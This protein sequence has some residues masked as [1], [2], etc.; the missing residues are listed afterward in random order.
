MMDGR[1]QSDGCIV[2]TKSPN[3]PEGTEGMEGRQP[4]KGNEQQGHISRTQGRREDMSKALERIRQAVRRDKKDKL[5]ALYH[6]VYNVDH[7]REAYWGLNTKAAPGVDGETWEHYGQ[8]LEANLQDLSGRLRRGAYRATPVRRVYIPKADGRQRPLG[9]PSLEDKIV[10]SV[11]AQILT[12]IWEEEFLGF[13]YG[14]RP[15]RSPHQ[16]LDALAVGIEAKSV[17]W[18]LDADIRGFYDAISHEWMVKFIE[19]RIGDRRVVGLIRKW[20]KAGVL[21]EG[22]WTLSEEGTPQG[23]LISPILANIYLHYAF[24]QWV[25]QWRQ[26]KARGDV[27]VVRYADDFVV[28]LAHRR[29]AERFERDLSERLKRFGLELHADKTRLIEFGR[30]AVTNRAERREGKPETFNF[31]GFTHICTKNRRNSFTVLRQTERK[32]MRA[33][34]REITEGLK[35]RMHK[36]IPEQGQWLR[37]VMEGH[38]QYYGVPMNGPALSE[39]RYH[40]LGIWKRVLDRRSQTSRVTWERMYRLQRKWMPS[41]R[42][43]HPYPWQRQ[44]VR[45]K[46]RAGCGNAARPD[47]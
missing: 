36:P 24:D 5:T 27:I 21:E 46:A 17:R 10:Q 19:H 13:S 42:I 6:H 39:F 11:V 20:L 40:I 15:G 26:R 23:G 44:G 35:R 9:V 34:L 41:T 30:Y 29:E 31:L 7:L 1:G 28:G 33:K 8:D 32:R 22:R 25:H 14:F 47:P 38:Y 37:S 3:K 43:R 18:V 2:P 12:V 4:A 16:A 45:P